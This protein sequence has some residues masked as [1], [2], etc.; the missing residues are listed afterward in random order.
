MPT[1]PTR[2]ADII[3]LFRTSA[4][5]VANLSLDTLDERTVLE[6]LGIDSVVLV[7]IVSGVERRAGVQIDDAALVRIR[8]LADLIEEIL[9]AQARTERLERP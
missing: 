2:R 6:D 3:D 5:E 1:T 8:V 4:R 9:R 7:E